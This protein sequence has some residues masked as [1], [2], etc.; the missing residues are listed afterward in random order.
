M[1]YSSFTTFFFLFFLLLFFNFKKEKKRKKERGMGRSDNDNDEEEEVGWSINDLET[2]S[3]DRHTIMRHAVQ[4]NK[5]MYFSSIAAFAIWS[6][7]IFCWLLPAVTYQNEDA[8]R[9]EIEYPV[10]I[11]VGGKK[12]VYDSALYS[13]AFLDPNYM[14]SPRLPAVSS[15]DSAPQPPQIT[16]LLGITGSTSGYSKRIDHA[17]S[18]LST[19]R[20]NATV[21]FDVLVVACSRTPGLSNFMAA[22][23]PPWVRVYSTQCSPSAITS[24]D[25][26][27][28]GASAAYGSYIALLDPLGG[29]FGDDAKFPLSP[30]LLTE[31]FHAV[32]SGE[33][34]SVVT[35]VLLRASNH[36]YVLSAGL[37]VAPVDSRRFEI[38]SRLGGLIRRYVGANG[39]RMETQEV[40]AGSL[41][42]SVSPRGVWT[43][44]FRA[45]YLDKSYV[46][47]EAQLTMEA[48]QRGVSFV[49]H[50]GYH[51]VAQPSL[52]R[53][54]TS[55][56]AVEA[57][58]E[59]PDTYR[60]ARKYAR[61]RLRY[62]AAPVAWDIDCACHSEY[63]H[64]A[65][66]ILPAL[67]PHAYLAVPHNK[68]CACDDAPPPGKAAIGRMQGRYASDGLVWVSHA[69]PPEYADVLHYLKTRPQH[70]VGRSG[71]P[72]QSVPAEWKFPLSFASQV[73]V[74]AQDLRTLVIDAGV[75]PSKVRYVPT[76]VD[77]RLYDPASVAP[78]E[79]VIEAAPPHKYFRFLSIIDLDAK[80]GFD[81]L[82]EAYFTA[83]PRTAA[84]ATDPPVILI[85][86]VTTP[87]TLANNVENAIARIAEDVM[88]KSLR[89]LPP[90]K[91]FTRTLDEATRPRLYRSADA[92]VLP[93]RAQEFCGS[94]VEAMAMGLPAAATD[95]GACKQA[96]RHAEPSYPIAVKEFLKASAEDFPT[97]YPLPKN[98]TLPEP[99]REDAAR[100]LRRMYENREKHKS[101]AERTRNVVL[102]KHSTD[103]VAKMITANLADLDLTKIIDYN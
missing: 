35:P 47:A 3:N 67:E 92:Y 89:D 49:V 26:L 55:M 91:V 34:R 57:L 7:I 16:F 11:I 51:I 88:G 41:L 74:P 64:E 90:V 100:Q 21:L 9:E 97:G 98:A 33:R 101:V 37:D 68:D 43:E 2:R 36:D 5:L 29:F 32:A 24:A 1:C 84:A 58:L 30:E 94:V 19:L 99:S 102:A 50:E 38:F 12:V 78:L 8:M 15:A 14:K 53:G 81:V 59:T 42:G 45:P 52:K 4:F 66:V 96:V 62:T 63:S 86:Q 70:I 6:A 85:L 48:R 25:V 27:L 31:L 75:D 10:H 54:S 28:T 69:A 17:I 83:F 61:R 56:E 72:F 79:Y 71:L 82:I 40:F 65:G 87:G 23:R 93:A 13:K 73:W 46:K 60:F 77:P 95:F 18:V 103:V 80:D 44:S 76:P 22:S 20:A 39:T